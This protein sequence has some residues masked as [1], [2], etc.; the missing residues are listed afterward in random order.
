MLC[1]NA[2]MSDFGQGYWERQRV[3]GHREKDKNLSL[4]SC[5]LLQDPCMLLQDS[6]RFFLSALPGI[7]ARQIKFEWGQTMAC[8]KAVWFF[9]SVVPQF[10]CC[11]CDHSCPVPKLT[12]NISPAS[13]PLPNLQ[14]PSER[15]ENLAIQCMSQATDW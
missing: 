3:E 13:A 11:T 8:V 10:L 6:A 14:A 7:Y 12:P 15:I 2:A 1:N 9:L 4:H 5:M